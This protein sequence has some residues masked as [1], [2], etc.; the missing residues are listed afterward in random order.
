MLGFYTSCPR[1]AP[2]KSWLPRRA[3][4]TTPQEVTTLLPWHH[5]WESGFWRGVHL[6]VSICARGRG[7][8]TAL[9][10]YLL[11]SAQGQDVYLTT[12][13]R[14]IPFYSPHGFKELPLNQQSIPQCAPACQSSCRSPWG[15]DCS[16]TSWL[17]CIDKHRCMDR[18][19]AGWST[20]QQVRPRLQTYHAAA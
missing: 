8:G 20:S 17:Q 6:H 3:S 2:C 1:W 12:L 13:Q 4:C 16:L 11:E 9:V 7:I 10:Q 18:C 5:L 19:S 15:P 14:S